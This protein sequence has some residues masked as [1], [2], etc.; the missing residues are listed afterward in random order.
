MPVYKLFYKIAKFGVRV[1]AQ[2]PELRAKT[3]SFVK[4]RVVPQAKAGWEKAKPRLEQAKDTA[5]GAAKDVADVARANDPRENPRK[6]L[7][8]ASQRLRDRAKR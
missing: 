3:A 8:E 4:D 7:S 1:L 5:V 6:F 2:N